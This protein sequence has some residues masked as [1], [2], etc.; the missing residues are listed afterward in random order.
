MYGSRAPADVMRVYE[1]L[2]PKPKEL[3]TNCQ[4][5]RFIRYGGS[6]RVAWIGTLSRPCPH[7]LLHWHTLEHCPDTSHPS[8]VCVSLFC[9]LSRCSAMARSM[10]TTP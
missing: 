10:C 2:N 7:A 9:A 5:R 6:G 8:H 4:H 3:I 1:L